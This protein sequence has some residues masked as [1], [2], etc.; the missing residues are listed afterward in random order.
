[1]SEAIR[2]LA[3][4]QEEKLT[5]H[6]DPEELAD[7]QDGL[8][9]EEDRLALQEHLAICRQC[10]RDFAE[11]AAIDETEEPVPTPQGREA[12]P[13][14]RTAYGNIRLMAA[15]FAIVALSSIALNFVMY[16]FAQKPDAPQTDMAL[17]DL[18]PVGES[19]ERSESVGEMNTVQN[20][21]NGLILFLSLL[22][23][24][25]GQVVRA[26]LSTS[27][28]RTRWLSDKITIGDSPII[29]IQISGT[30]LEPDTYH[31]HLLKEQ[32]NEVI[33]KFTF[34]LTEPKP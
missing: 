32:D 22:E 7:Y 14:S 12:A 25:Q 8:L 21:P 10:M 2:G 16:R 4:S 24:R 27:E 9:P 31:I 15:C 13:M 11:L 17:L 20:R 33:A 26:R 30:Y 6:P 28:T 23:D 34:K 29:P 5:R 1:M 3:Q 18:L 19:V